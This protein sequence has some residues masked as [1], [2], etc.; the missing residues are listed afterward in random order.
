MVAIFYRLFGAISSV[1]AANPVC[2]AA[3]G[4]GGFMKAVV[5]LAISDGLLAIAYIQSEKFSKVVC[6]SA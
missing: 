6:S 4:H 2:I 3:I 1:N 5:I